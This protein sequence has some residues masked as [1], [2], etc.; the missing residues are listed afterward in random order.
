MKRISLVLMCVCFVPVASGQRALNTGRNWSQFH[1]QN[2]QRWNPYETV[3]NV[4]NVGNLAL[5][6][7][8]TTGGAG[9]VYPRA[10]P[11]AGTWM[12]LGGTSSASGLLADN[13][14]M[15]LLTGGLH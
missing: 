6:W 5:L 10:V 15:P 11:G 4:N 8:Y 1:R 13:S 2:M 14:W 3:L 7:S 9:T 12:A